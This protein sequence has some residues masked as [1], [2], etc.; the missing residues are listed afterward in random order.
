MALTRTV[1]DGRPPVRLER[2]RGR[3]VR[4]TTVALLLLALTVMAVRVRDSLEWGASAV[5]RQVPAGTRFFVDPQSGAAEW[6]R[7]NPADRRAAMIR[8]RV[9]SRPQ[10]VWFT[11]GDPGSVQWEVH[12][13]VA[14]AAARSEVP[15]LVMY[16]IPHRDCAM[17]SAGGAPSLDAYRRWV[18]GFSRGL[19]P[20]PAWIIL[21]P[22]S[23][24]QVG[25]LAPQ[26]RAARVR[27]VRDAARTLRSGHPSVRIYFDAGNSSWRSVETMA[28]RLRLAHAAEYGN[29]IALN[30][31]NFNHT[32]DEVRFGIQVIRS[33][34]DRDLRMVVDTGRNGNGRSSGSATCDPAGRRLGSLPTADTGNSWVDAFLWIKPPGQADGCRGAAGSFLPEAAYRLARRD[35]APDAGAG[36]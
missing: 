17:R 23:L 4:A 24:A 35:L 6:V 32:D 27:A 19:A 13:V 15:V 2:P 12:Q 1:K 21:E 7:S 25:C 31:A 22:D 18:D 28:S 16:A 9:A 3:L 29:G 8:H 33:L 26:Q 14:G 20:L 10:A 11:S 36:R 5:P 34:G 30:I